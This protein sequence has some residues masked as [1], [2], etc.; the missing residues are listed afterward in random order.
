M[1]FL[2]PVLWGRW[3]GNFL[4]QYTLSI[5]WGRVSHGIPALL[6][7]A[8][9]GSGLLITLGDGTDWRNRL[10][11]QRLETAWESDDYE[12]T[13]LIVR[14][15]L[16]HD[17]DDS[18][19][20][21]QLGLTLCAK[22][23]YEKGTLLLRQLVEHHKHDEAALWLLKEEYDGKPWKDL[24][25]Q[26]REELG[27]ILSV[28][29]GANPNDFG[30]QT[31]YVEYLIATQRYP[32]ALPI[33]EKLAITE[34]MRGLQGAAIARH[35]GRNA[36]AD[37]LAKRTLEEMAKTSR[38]EPTNASLAMSVA[39]NQLFLLRHEDAIQ[40][41]AIAIRR[42]KNKN[43]ENKLRSAIGDSYVAWV[44][45]IE[46]TPSESIA[47]KL[48]IL[49]LLQQALQFAPQ[50]QRVLALVAD[51]VL[52]SADEDEEEIAEIRRA[53]IEGTSPGIAHFIQGTT[54]LLKD[55]SAKAMTH[56]KIAAELLPN[57]GAILN[58]LAVALTK[59]GDEHLEEALKLS[60]Q[61]VST[62]KVP[63]PHFYETRGQIRL[64]LGKHLEA[65]PDLER[66]LQHPDLAQKAH[67]ALAECYE[68]IG[69]EDLANEHRKKAG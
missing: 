22:G 30:V 31:M 55:D 27:I 56:L 43:D 1:R 18:D 11:D 67:A 57:S 25:E 41:L 59:Q 54:A 7:V 48:R 52:A 63:P 45:H 8:L 36:L 62:L 60:D 33:L 14:R 34:P 68:A 9:L 50:N 23:D 65:I 58:N 32:Q 29:H 28:L 46:T 39:Q 42:A 40:T 69:D 53:L 13:E 6:L 2:N 15:K 5:P 4:V 66:A 51:R 21:F 26:Q 17:P 38:E 3:L 12:T 37:R 61:A 44:Q 20:V 49:K 10:L 24:S 64:R 19:S 35:L 47:A 16:T